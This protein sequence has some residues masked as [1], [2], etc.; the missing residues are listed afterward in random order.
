MKDTNDVT[1][2]SDI[3]AIAQ[4]YADEY[5]C[6]ADLEHSGN[7]YNGGA[8]GENLARGFNFQKASGVTAWFNE[9]KYYNYSE[10]GFTEDT[11][12]FTQLVWSETTEIGCGYKNCGSYWGYYVVCNYSPPGNVGLV[13]GSDPNYF[14]ER[15]VHEPIDPATAEG[16]FSL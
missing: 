11:G 10:P 12:H 14:Y 8:L 13:G 9:I 15:D 2:N 16:N 5:T 6:G 7:S 3:A 4:S 1:W